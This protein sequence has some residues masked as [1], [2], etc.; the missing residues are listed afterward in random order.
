MS[1]I[2]GDCISADYYNETEMSQISWRMNVIKYITA[3]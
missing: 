2:F 3:N 1:E